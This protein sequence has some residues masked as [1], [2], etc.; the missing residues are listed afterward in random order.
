MTAIVQDDGLPVPQ[1]YWSMA[2]IALG[3]TIAVLDSA[4]A[5]IALP[6]I[7]HELHATP[8]ESIWVINAYQ[9]AIIIALLPLAA[10][11]EIVGYR[12]VYLFGLA[13]F[14]L[15]SLGC[16]LSHNLGWL[17]LA[18]SVQG[19]GAAGVMA[20]NGALVRF[21]YPSRLLGRGVGLNAL[22]VSVAAAIGPTIAAGILAVGPWE[23]LFAV[24][25]PLGLFALG[26][27]ARVLPS[28]DRSGRRFDYLSAALNALAFGLTFIGVD[29][30]THAAHAPPA[31][32]QAAGAQSAGAWSADTLFAGA[33]TGWVELAVAV[34][35]AVIL[36]R[37]ERSR[38]RPLIPIDLL[39]IR[40]F[41]LSVATSVASFAAQILAFI[42][43]PFYFEGALHRDQVQTGL[44]MTPWP[45]AV[46]VIAPI[47]GP[48][49]DRVP[50]ALLG[51]VGLAMLAAGLTSL[52][53]L[54]AHAG[55]GD[56]VWRMALCGL[57]FG[58][59]QSPNNRVLLSSAP[60]ERAGAA[61]GM[62]ATARLTG[63][64]SGAALA[65]GLFRLSP[66][67][68]EVACLTAAAGLAAAAAAIS[69]TRL[70]ASPAPLTA[71]P[72][73]GAPLGATAAGRGVGPVQ[74]E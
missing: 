57:G 23:W 47:A 38:P 49:S 64:T 3:I 13:L 39:R 71:P 43:L 10:L 12:R 6:A 27:A 58:L 72:L 56:V 65:A 45:V 30:L 69:L 1:R 70:A 32:A 25:V 66:R 37:R 40:I 73:R 26:L 51:G 74:D 44:L 22:V 35:A 9:V 28:S 53:L 17:I 62:L 34:A 50:A 67:Q 55:V 42:A 59:F 48:L 46:G 15:S 20:V 31:G 36:V 14:T 7:A 41:A 54:S 16:A 19:L 68:G 2:A 5:N 8:A 11:G 18:R 52:A 61:G 21:T 29:T 60:R 33:A 63:L 4:I 24:N